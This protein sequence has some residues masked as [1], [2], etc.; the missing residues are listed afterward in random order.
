MAIV[1]PLRVV[2]VGLMALTIAACSSTGVPH[3]AA[4]RT[5]HS[6]AVAASAT[7]STQVKPRGN[8]GRLKA[9]DGRAIILGSDGLGTVDFGT[10]KI[11]ATAELTRLLGPPSGHGSNTGC[12]PTFT[13]VDW[14]ELAVEFHN[15]AF[16]GYRDIDRPQGDLDPWP[17]NGGY[18]PPYPARPVARTA[19]GIRLGDS[20]GQCKLRIPSSHWQVR[21]GTRL[22]TESAS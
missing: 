4:A 2:A 8:S 10:S 15:N 22:A 14:G 1:A 20:L 12:G 5:S 18:P 19:A 11:Q 13:E 16:S 6:P 9:L 3:R 17:S 21:I 7:R